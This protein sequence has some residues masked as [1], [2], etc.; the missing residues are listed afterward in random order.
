M[1][2]VCIDILREWCDGV[3]K[4]AA[5]RTHRDGVA[6]PRYHKKDLSSFDDDF[7]EALLG[8]SPTS[9]FSSFSSFSEDDESARCRYLTEDIYF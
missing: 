6:S 7:L 3:A 2:C 1:S 8:L 4:W 9:S 5:E